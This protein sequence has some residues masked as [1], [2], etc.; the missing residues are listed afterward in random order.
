MKIILEWIAP[1]RQGMAMGTILAAYSLAITLDFAVGIPYTIA[2]GWPQFFSA[3][4]VL[5]LVVALLSLL[6][7]RT[8]PYAAT[9][10]G[11]S[12]AAT[13][14]RIAAIFKSKWLYV[15]V[16]AIFGDLFALAASV[17]WVIPNFIKTQGMSPELAPVVGSVLGLAQ[18]GFL[19]I[20]GFV[21]DRIAR[22][23]VLKLGALLAL[24]AAL[25][26]LATTLWPFPVAILMLVAVLCGV[27][28]FSGGAIFSLVGERFGPSLGAPATAYAEVGG[29]LATFVAPALMGAI[30]GGSGSFVA[31]FWS[32]VIVEAIVCGALFYLLR[33]K[34]SD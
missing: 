34:R 33:T 14:Q 22:E 10:L 32:F 7:V 5:T 23:T 24:G 28:V 21:A 15:G 12:A 19:L 18:I 2:H 26:C 16:L 6:L 27:A 3:L 31:S 17:T 8:G 11:T 4:G 30:L 9:P 20:G 13:Q 25:L 1:K 29:V